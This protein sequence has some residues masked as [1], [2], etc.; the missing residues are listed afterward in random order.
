[1]STVRFV[2]VLCFVKFYNNVRISIDIAEPGQNFPTHHL[3]NVI[4]SRLRMC[5]TDGGIMLCN[6]PEFDRK[7]QVIRSRTR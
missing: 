6:R 2:D 1:M 5:P 3:H 4:W 7:S